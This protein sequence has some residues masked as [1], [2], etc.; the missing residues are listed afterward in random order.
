MQS[1][2]KKYLVQVSASL[3]PKFGGPHAVV[4]GTHPRLQRYYDCPLLVFGF[5]TLQGT[6]IHENPTFLNNRFGF[7]F[8]RP[9]RNTRN[10]LRNADILLLHGFYLWSTLVSIHYSKTNNVFLMPHGSLERYQEKNG[11]FKKHLFTLVVGFLLKS[12][13]IHFL[14]GSE[15]EV[16]S[17]RLKFPD[18]DISVVGL[19][20]ES[21][22]GPNYASTLHSPIRLFCL[23]RISSEKRLDLCIRAIH[24]LNI[25]SPKYILNI[26][27]LGSEALERELKN[28]VEALGIQ[29]S[30]NFMGHVE[31]DA[32]TEALMNSDIFLLPSENENFAV[33]V[34]ESIAFGK[35]VV[36]SQFVATHQFVDKHKAGITI[37]QLEVES[38]VVGIREV[39]NNFSTIQ[40]NC[41][42][43]APLLDWDVVIRRWTSAIEDNSAEYVS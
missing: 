15:M 29:Q 32:K 18:A 19:G 39:T 24:S 14:V 2:A 38:L 23:S 35:P 34:A 27:G 12:R 20:V 17:V 10:S 36:V 6:N 3:H 30:V 11:G 13:R 1:Q 40:R 25:T 26:Y 21:M 5:S 7:S 37:N 28:L 4:A 22:V 42:S 33:A 9:N 8:R 41:V 43:S 31:G 16:S